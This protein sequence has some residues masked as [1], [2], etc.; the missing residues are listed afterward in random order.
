MDQ[1]IEEYLVC[2]KCSH[3]VRTSEA[4]AIEC[5]YMKIPVAW[6]L[7]CTNCSGVSIIPYRGYPEL[8]QTNPF[9]LWTIPEA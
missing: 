1:V 9:S 8:F 6:K 2:P 5:R 7:F 3:L 4:L